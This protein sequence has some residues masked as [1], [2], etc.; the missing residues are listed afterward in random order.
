V[1]EAVLALWL[2]IHVAAWRAHYAVERLHREHVD[3]GGEA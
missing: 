1:S 3:L 2:A